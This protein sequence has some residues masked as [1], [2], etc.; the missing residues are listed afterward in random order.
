MITSTSFINSEG[1]NVPENKIVVMP[2][3]WSYP[4]HGD[5][6][7]IIVDF[8]SNP[9]RDWFTAHFYY[10]LPIGI[11]NQYGFGVKSMY[12]IRAIW[13]G[14]QNA[15]D[16]I[17]QVEDEGTEQ[18]LVA[19][20]FG[21]GILTFQNNF[22]FRTEPG[23][24]IMVFPPPN[25]FI[26][27]I[28]SMTGV[29]ETDNLRRDFTFN[30]KITEPNREVFIKKGD[31]ISAFM[32]IQ[33]YYIDKFDL[34]NASDIFSNDTLEKERNEVHL[35]NEQRLGEDMKKPHESGRKYYHGLHADS[36]KYPDHQKRVRAGSLDADA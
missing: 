18:Q 16:T 36:S 7:N 8:R 12:N 14:G 30:L 33:R 10:C 22:M 13:N 4:K 9:K 34:V 21:S 6:D 23:V 17:F 27:G 29:I 31:I 11:G 15:D 28:S 20:Q 3:H 25:H 32:P 19:S 26:P 1:N 24:N 5:Y 35:F 2:H